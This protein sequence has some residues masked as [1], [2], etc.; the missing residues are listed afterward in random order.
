[1]QSWMS[2]KFVLPNGLRFCP[3][4]ISANGRIKTY[5]VVVGDRARGQAWKIYFLSLSKR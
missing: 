1:L 2:S 5:Y 3:V 4:A